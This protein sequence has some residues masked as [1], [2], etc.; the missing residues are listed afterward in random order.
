MDEVESYLDLAVKLA[1]DAGAIQLEHLGRIK[2][3]KFKGVANIVTEVD[4][5]CERMIIDGIGRKFPRHGVLGEEMGQSVA[6]DIGYQWIIDPL[7]GTT[8][9]SHSYPKFC[10]SIGLVFEGRVQVGVVYDPVMDELFH[11]ARGRGAFLNGKPI[12]VSE[13][14]K[15]ADSL[16]ATG[17]SYDRGERLDRSFKLHGTILPEAMSIRCDGSAALDLCYVAC[18]RY[19]GFWELSLNVWDIAAGTLIIEE[20]GG[21]WSDLTGRPMDLDN[22][23]FLCTNGSIR[24]ELLELIKGL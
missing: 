20:A 16:L 2:H 1:R 8:N 17:F 5:E 21:A 18:G 4:L 9:Y 22:P 3:V 10:V 6:S 13:T 23:E 7:D 12:R 14:D 15:L 11:A 24:Q 19:D